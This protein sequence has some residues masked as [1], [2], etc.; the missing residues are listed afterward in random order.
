VSIMSRS[1]RVI[2]ALRVAGWHVLLNMQ[3][4]LAY[5]APASCPAASQV[6]RGA[7]LCRDGSDAVFCRLCACAC[8][9]YSG[10]AGGARGRRMPRLLPTV[11]GKLGD[12][13][14]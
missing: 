3:L 12:E 7:G 2:D 14:G 6:V 5:P 4:M 13:V 8:A 11:L 1:I 9:H 10:R